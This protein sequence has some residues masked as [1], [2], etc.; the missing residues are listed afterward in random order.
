MR[1]QDVVRNGSPLCKAEQ[2][3]VLY[4]RCVREGQMLQMM[5]VI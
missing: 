4:M 5:I 3:I 2:A 1:P